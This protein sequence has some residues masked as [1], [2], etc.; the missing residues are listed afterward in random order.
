[1]G[2]GSG[3]GAPIGELRRELGFVETLS[4]VIGRIIGSG[5][6]RTPGLMMIAVSLGAINEA[7]VAIENARLSVGLFY[8]A[9]IIGG[10]ATILGA[11]CYAELVAMLPRSGG[12]YAYL[13]AAYPEVWTFLR[14]WAMFFVSET[15]AI[16][17]V[18]LV[19]AEYSG[20]LLR[21]SGVAMPPGYEAL[22]AL[23]LIW[24]MSAA[25]CFGVL[26]SGWLQ[27]LMS[28]L[29]L[30]ALAM[31]VGFCFA[32]DGDARSLSEPLWPESFGFASMVGVARALRYGFFAYSGW[33]G[34]TYVAEEVRNP[35]RNLPLSILI[36]IGAVMTIYLGVNAGYLYQLGALEMALKQ[37]EVAAAAM[38]K[39]AGPLGAALIAIAVLLS[40]SGNVST[41]I[42]VK[43]RSWFAMARDGLFFQSM[44]RLHPRYQTPNN[45]ILLQAG[46]ASV[47]LVLAAYGQ[48]IYLLALPFVNTALGVLGQA[49]LEATAQSGG[50][51]DRVID[52]FSFT[53]A[54]FNISTFIAV[55]VLRKKM[56]DLPRPFRTPLLPITLGITLLIQCWFAGLTLYDRPAESLYGLALTLS[57]LLYYRFVVLRRRQ[58]AA[59]L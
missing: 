10:V 22:L 45:A 50:A 23:A 39:A 28:F 14:G 16:V 12:P 26:L 37:K 46:W 43:A 30:F 57:G 34:A 2:G 38:E 17:A 20:A 56:P 35:S 5:I 11:L 41:Q 36:G 3:Q 32:G 27:N 31:I 9:W 52:Y 53:S 40:A 8:L 47:L 21:R 55:L 44:S 58:A 29:K 48:E 6:F 33:E 13:R 54:I 15:A 4:I 19:F 49:P 42:L 59:S 24:L 25:N 7:G 1:M 18:S 51:Y